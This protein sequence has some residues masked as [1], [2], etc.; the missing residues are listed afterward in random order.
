MPQVGRFN[1][2][3]PNP[4]DAVD[5]LTVFYKSSTSLLVVGVCATATGLGLGGNAA[6]VATPTSAILRVS[7]QAPA[8]E[9]SDTMAFQTPP[10]PAALLTVP[11]ALAAPPA[12]CTASPRN[13][14][15]TRDTNETITVHTTRGADVNLVIH[16]PNTTRSFTI[17]A[18]SAGTAVSTFSI[19]PS[20][21]G[22]PVRVDVSTNSGQVCSTQFTPR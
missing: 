5:W 11:P 6:P 18:D 22:Y 4:Q 2:A 10:A 8:G 7:T 9:S 15:P 20:V 14:T 17:V 16:D 19:S 3:C 21:P 13:A 1:D 12:P